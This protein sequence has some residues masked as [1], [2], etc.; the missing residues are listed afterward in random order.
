MREAQ[1]RP[2]SIFEIPGIQKVTAN[3][4][5]LVPTED[6][7]GH[8]V[9]SKETEL[10]EFLVDDTLFEKSEVGYYHHQPKKVEEAV[11]T[12][13]SCDVNNL[14]L[15]D[16]ETKHDPKTSLHE[17][18]VDLA[19]LN[20]RDCIVPLSKYSGC[21][22][23]QYLKGGFFK[24]HKD[25][26]KSVTHFATV[27][28]LI[29][30]RLSPHTGGTLRVWDEEEKIHEFNTET[31]EQVTVVMFHPSLFHEVLPITS[32]TRVVFK[33]D[34]SYNKNLFYLASAPVLANVDTK[35]VQETI[36]ARLG[37][38]LEGINKSS[39]KFM[40]LMA[41][42]EDQWE[43]ESC[44]FSNTGG[45]KCEACP[46]S[47]LDRVA[48]LI[49]YRIRTA[50]SLQKQLKQFDN[51]MKELNTLDRRASKYD[52]NALITAIRKS[53]KSTIIVRLINF[54]PQA[55]EAFLYQAD[56]VLFQQLKE[57][58]PDIGVRN[59]TSKDRECGMSNTSGSLST[60][61]KDHDSWDSDPDYAKNVEILNTGAYISIN[62][63]HE[64]DAEEDV[65]EETNHRLPTVSIKASI[66]V[67]ERQSVYNDST[68]DTKFNNAYTCF[69]IRL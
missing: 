62:I 31:M 66:G 5:D 16:G 49:E 27:L 37:E 63:R 33:Y 17:R 13:K 20:F 14:F 34:M 50:K 38:L 56:S 9:R 2:I 15:F 12:S 23:V 51:D 35:K 67:R 45:T 7:R 19:P 32:G 36:D 59:M 65:E 10:A 25:S 8:Y 6:G 53:G 11:R 28:V 60:Y 58:F 64:Y 3:H 52:V 41:V 44:G 47:S 39:E 30:S 57:Q 4:K 48:E 29:P 26:I 42:T 1:M 54:Y 43:C 61:Q 18:I 40:Q 55:A 69:I 46:D 22:A 24:K 68:Y 21:K